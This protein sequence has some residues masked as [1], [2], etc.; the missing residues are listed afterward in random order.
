MQPDAEPQNAPFDTRFFP[1]HVTLLTVG[2]NMMPMG[3]WTVISK[4]PFRFLICMQLGNHSLILL[5]K[6]KEAAL[7][8][9]PWSERQ[10]VVR[11]GYLS[12]R[13]G[14]KAEK[15]GFALFPAEQLEHTKLVEGADSIYETTV[16]TELKD[17]SSQFALFVLDV[18]AT[19]GTCLPTDREP[20]MYLSE[21][22]FAALGE[23]WRY[24][25]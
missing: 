21:K 4:D 10:R 24:R 8:F 22:D 16:L 20:I 1:Q 12:G 14:N 6:Y 15:L 9:L 2:E 23:N 17:L 3:Y 11:A 7:H 18:V 25:R 13:D 19:H 5:K